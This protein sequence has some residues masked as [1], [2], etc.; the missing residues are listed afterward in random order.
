MAASGLGLELGGPFLSSFAQVGWDNIPL[1]LYR[2]S[3]S[4]SEAFFSV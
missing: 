4:G 2:A 1:A 3:I